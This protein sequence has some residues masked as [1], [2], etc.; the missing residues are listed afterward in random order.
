MGCLVCCFYF[1]IDGF[2][3]VELPR[4][5]LGSDDSTTDSMLK[6]CVMTELKR[7]R[8]NRSFAMPTVCTS[9]IH[10]SQDL[11]NWLAVF[12]MAQFSTFLL[13][14][15]CMRGIYTARSIAIVEWTTHDPELDV[16]ERHFVARRELDVKLRP[17][18]SCQAHAFSLA[19]RAFRESCP[20]R[21]YGSF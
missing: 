4:T 14:L 18:R 1:G 21:L 13:Q 10:D 19:S 15:L 3:F 16:I 11:W 5:L 8:L 6:L 17:F 12:L 20:C 9:L 7:L 2:T